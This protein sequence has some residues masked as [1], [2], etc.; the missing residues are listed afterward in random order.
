MVKKKPKKHVQQQ[1]AEEAMTTQARGK[2]KQQ[3][4]TLKRLPK[5]FRDITAGT[6]DWEAF[7]T[8]TGRRKEMEVWDNG[9]ILFLSPLNESEEGILGS[10][11]KLVFAGGL[12]R[13][14]EGEFEYENVEGELKLEQ[15]NW[16]L[17][18]RDAEEA[19]CSWIYLPDEVT[20]VISALN[21]LFS[22]FGY[23]VRAKG[24]LMSER[25]GK[26]VGVV[27]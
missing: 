7:A 6:R 9:P 5:D 16:M 14:V 8:I 24:R 4:S 3:I 12:S 17:I 21:V 23:N 27:Y 19:G 1:I 10:Q 2:L 11:N 25:S 15:Y 26:P 13:L 18:I 22:H 20:E